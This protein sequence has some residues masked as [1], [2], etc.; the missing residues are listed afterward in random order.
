MSDLSATEKFATRLLYRA[1]GVD[2]ELAEG[3]LA[4]IQVDAIVCPANN[5]LQMRG[6]LARDLR[7]KGGDSIEREAM[8]IGIL[9][10][11]SAVITSAGRLPCRFIIHA[12]TVYRPMD[13]ASP[14]SITLATRA[15]LECAE[16]NS[17]ASVA[18]PALGTGTGAVSFDQSALSILDQIRRTIDRGLAKVT[19]IV[20]VAYER[21][22]YDAILSNLHVLTEVRRYEDRAAPP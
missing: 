5:F 20:I 19:R 12:P 22:F 4:S 1:A 17:I 9:D 13:T 8:N 6:G 3:D 11:G 2:V 14:L 7:V 15:A 16:V 21:E 10:S 18:I